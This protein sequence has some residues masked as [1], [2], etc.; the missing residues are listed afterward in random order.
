[1]HINGFI[2]FALVFY[3]SFALRRNNRETVRD[4]ENTSVERNLKQENETIETFQRLINGYDKQI[5]PYFGTGQ[6]TNVL[7]DIYVASFDSIRESHMDYSLTLHLRQ[8]WT[9][10]RLRHEGTFL[11]P[12]SHIIDDIWL[13]DLI[14]TNA[15][16]SKFHDITFL[17][18]V[19]NISE[20][21]EVLYITRLSL[22]LS[23]AMDFHHFPLDQ[24]KCEM[25]MESFKYTTDELQ[26]YWV[27]EEPA[28]FHGNHMKLPQYEIS[29]IHIGECNKVLKTGKY[30]CIVVEYLFSRNIGYYLLQTYIPSI[31]LVVMS[32]VSF[33]I[34]IKSSP[35]RV[36]LG[37]TTVL[38][39]ITATNGV[40]EDLPHVSYVKAIDIWFAACLIF[41]IGALLEFAIVHHFSVT[42]VKNKNQWT[43][44]PTKYATSDNAD[45]ESCIKLTIV[46]K[47]F[48]NEN[49]DD[50]RRRHDRRKNYRDTAPPRSPPY[51][52]QANQHGQ[53]SILGSCC[54]GE[55]KDDSY[56]FGKKIDMFCRFAFPLAFFIFNVAYWGY[57]VKSKEEPSFDI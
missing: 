55:K 10:P 13:P 53:V 15:K 56:R 22:L 27:H 8:R 23:C 9:D 46:D 43:N 41:V 38:T 39:M 47:S 57:Y 32:W 36:A 31:L 44:S 14:F 51:D 42:K 52:T 3:P 20:T 18:K 6:P 25:E 34:E 5:R 33:W 28:E 16:E 24:Q 49:A 37:V 11:P 50:G 35:A 19:V 2:C 30:S 45:V 21:G 4:V 54:H 7:V 48:D 29:G 26:Y 40:R 17:N 1:M 12:T